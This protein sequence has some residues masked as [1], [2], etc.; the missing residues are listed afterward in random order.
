MRELLFGK[1]LYLFAVLDL[2]DKDL[3]RFEAGDKMLVN[4]QGGIPGDIAG[5][6]LFSFLI[7]ETP[8]TPDIDVV[9]ARHGILYH[10]KECLHRCGH[11]RLVHACLFGNLVDNVCFGH[12]RIFLASEFF[13]MANLPCL[14][15]FKN[16]Y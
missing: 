15:R 12:C 8:K 5:D 1:L 7:D 3:G 13:G 11:I 6:F 14:A 2:V 4:D 9:P 16:E 10:T